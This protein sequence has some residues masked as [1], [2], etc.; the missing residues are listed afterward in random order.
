VTKDGSTEFQARYRRT[1]RI[2]VTIRMVVA[3]FRRDS[4]T[5]RT[6]RVG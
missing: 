5:R 3:S 4:D 2:G 6:V 1:V